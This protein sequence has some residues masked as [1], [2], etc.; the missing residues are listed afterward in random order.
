MKS[1]AVFSTFREPFG[2]EG[3]EDPTSDLHT[4]V[5]RKAVKFIEYFLNGLLSELE[6]SHQVIRVG[7]EEIVVFVGLI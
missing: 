5:S 2:P 7:T 1:T 3:S 4:Y 6:W